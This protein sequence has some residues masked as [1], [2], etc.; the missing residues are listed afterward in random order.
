MAKK[1]TSIESVPALLLAKDNEVRGKLVPEGTVIFIGECAEGMTI[2]DIDKAIARG[3]VKAQM[4]EIS[5]ENEE[6]DTKND[7]KEKGPE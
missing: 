5:F 1:R 3:N 6:N 2:T 4:T 7:S